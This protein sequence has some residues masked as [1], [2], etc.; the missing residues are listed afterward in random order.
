MSHK[1]VSAFKKDERPLDG[2][3]AI[4]D[5]MRKNPHDEW[6]IVARVVNK[7]TAI[8]HEDGDAAVVSAK[9]AHIE[10]MWGDDEATV[11]Q[12]LLD[13]YKQRT[14]GSMPTPPEPEPTLFDGD[15]PGGEAAE[16]GPVSEKQ[17]DVWLGDKGAE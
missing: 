1:I 10:P 17:P 8:E 3:T 16:D 12:M 2:L 5:E 14:G 13:A 4:E 6:Y 7:R 11:K 15:Q 9:L